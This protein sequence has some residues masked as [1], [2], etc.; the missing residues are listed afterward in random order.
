M[1]HFFS[2]FSPYPEHSL[3]LISAFKLLVSVNVTSL[4]WTLFD[5]FQLRPIL[6]SPNFYFLYVLK[7][8]RPYLFLFLLFVSLL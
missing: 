8:L 3:Y 2:L 5:L 1:T 4:W 7:I 6:S